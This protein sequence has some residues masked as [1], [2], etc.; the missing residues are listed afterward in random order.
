MEYG[1]FVVLIRHD[2]STLGL[3]TKTNGQHRCFESLDLCTQKR[4]ND[5]SS[6]SSMILPQRRDI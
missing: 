1:N 4:F 3:G 2:S 6:L 5:F